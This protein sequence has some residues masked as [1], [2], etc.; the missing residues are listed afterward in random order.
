MPVFNWTR[1]PF[2]PVT[3]QNIWI[4]CALTVVLTGS[5]L[6]IWRL[7]FLRTMW[8]KDWK[9][10]MLEM[11]LMPL[12][13]T[14]H[15]LQGFSKLVQVLLQRHD[16]RRYVKIK[17]CGLCAFKKL[18]NSYLLK[19]MTFFQQYWSMILTPTRQSTLE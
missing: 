9:I 16:R 15:Q 17:L 11:S 8:M 5:V 10:C 14:S 6:Y 19:L 2:W 3:R 1:H 4:F 12:S 18:K 13:R 7:W